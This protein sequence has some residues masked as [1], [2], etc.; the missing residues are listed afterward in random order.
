MTN[1]NIDSNS[2]SQSGMSKN[3]LSSVRLLSGIILMLPFV[4]LFRLSCLVLG[5][6]R[7]TKLAGSVVGKVAE[8]FVTFTIPKMNSGMDFST[9]I[10]RAIKNF[11]SFSILYEVK[12]ERQTDKLVEFRILNCPFVEGLKR[13]GAAELCK[14]ACAADFRIADKNR[15]NWKF[16]RSHSLGTDGQC[17]DHTYCSL[18]ST[19]ALEESDT[20]T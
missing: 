15:M 20:F 1:S 3:L 19:V 14:Y 18:N 8:I 5:K 4:V 12:V 16:R 6:K 17:C 10:D 11:L 2:T 13:L 7:A 9:F